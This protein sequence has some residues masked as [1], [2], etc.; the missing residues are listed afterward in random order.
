MEEYTREED[1]G[2][3]R[4]E[5]GRTGE[6]DA[7]TGWERG[8]T[9]HW[10]VGCSIARRRDELPVED[11]EEEEEEEVLLMGISDDNSWLLYTFLG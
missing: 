9:R 11:Q 4:R 10:N 2:E 6:M 5:N 8:S 1:T 7:E 3:E